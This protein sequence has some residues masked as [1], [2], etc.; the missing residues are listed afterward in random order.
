MKAKRT[1]SQRQ[2]EH[3]KSVHEKRSKAARSTPQ[4]KAAAAFYLENRCDKLTLS[5][6]AFLL[7]EAGHK[8]PRGRTFCNAG[9]LALRRKIQRLKNDGEA[10]TVLNALKA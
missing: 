5:E 8:T 4:F 3:L 9:V 1:P 2:L 10:R 6:A 7:N